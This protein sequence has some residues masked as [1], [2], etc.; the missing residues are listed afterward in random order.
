MVEMAQGVEAVLSTVQADLP[1]T[2]PRQVWK[3]VSA[4]LKRHAASFLSPAREGA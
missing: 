1:E 3:A 4:G 2:F